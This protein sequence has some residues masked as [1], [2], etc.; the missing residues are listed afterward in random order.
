MT[1]KQQ[2]INKVP[3]EKALYSREMETGQFPAK[4]GV[5]YGNQ[6]FI[7]HCHKEAEIL[8]IR[9]GNL[10]VRMDGEE[11]TVKQ[12][13]FLIVPP[14]VSHSIESAS[15]DCIREVILIEPSVMGMP[16]SG[17]YESI[18]SAADILHSRSG[19]SALW[20]QKASERCIALLQEF[21]REYQEKKPGWQLALRASAAGILLVLL[22][23][24]PAAERRRSTGM[25]KLQEILEYIAEH[26]T[27]AIRLE[28]CA[29]AAGFNAT[30][31][32]RYFSQAM[33]TPF[34][35]YVKQLRIDK[36]KWLLR[37]SRMPVSEVAYCCGY[38]DVRTLNRLFR[39]VTGSAPLA[40]RRMSAENRV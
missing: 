5:M 21:I 29:A 1:N 38:N 30:Y 36:A 3:G 11:Y 31:F 23:D 32:S 9:R 4:C 24:A 33:G 26:Y 10:H 17:E 2:A 37:T 39:Q 22:R 8:Y 35:E 19:Y 16:E 12:D 14:F 20:E 6:P 25:E 15:D 7:R 18:L 13:E 27:G 34:Q 28:D 40:F